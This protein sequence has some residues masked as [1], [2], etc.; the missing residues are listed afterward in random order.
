MTA[1]VRAMTFRFNRAEMKKRAKFTVRE[2]N[3]S[4]IPV[5]VDFL[6]NL[7]LHVS[8]AERQSLSADAINRLEEL[9]HDYIDNEEKFMVVACTKDDEVVGMGNIQIWHSPNLWEEAEEPDLKSGFIDDLWVEPGY[10]KQGI[11]SLMLNALVDFAERHDIE[12]LILEYSIT[13]KEAAAAWESLGFTP[14]GVRAAANTEAV[15][16]KLNR[17]QG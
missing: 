8:G 2:A 13:N 14:T 17:A 1:Q 9:L 16:Q 11:M 4:D 7:T 5:L 3:E 10:R 6:V 12:E 15:R